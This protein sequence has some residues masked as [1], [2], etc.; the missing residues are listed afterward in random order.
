MDDKKYKY[1]IRNYRLV[2]VPRA[3]QEPVADLNRS[4]I[5]ALDEEQMIRRSS[6]DNTEA[7][8]VLQKKS[9]LSSTHA[10][11]SIADDSE[12]LETPAPLLN[13]LPVENSIINPKKYRLSTKLT[14]YSVID[15]MDSTLNPGPSFLSSSK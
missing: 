2:K 15:M 1:V 10:P 11:I 13:T 14:D 7:S 5:P 12:M 3:M 6:V 8:R 4:M 9:N